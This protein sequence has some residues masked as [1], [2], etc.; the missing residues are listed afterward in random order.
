MNADIKH[1][2]SQEQSCTSSV[3][4]IAVCWGFWD[5][6]LEE[7]SLQSLLVKGFSVFLNIYAYQTIF[8]DIYVC[9]LLW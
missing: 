6:F 7:L 5:F 9:I 2:Y 8:R 4:F 3:A 1:V